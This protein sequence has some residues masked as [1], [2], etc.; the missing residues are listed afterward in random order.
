MKNI[1][2]F[3]FANLPK[4][5]EIRKVSLAQV[6]PIKVGRR[7]QCPQTHKK[8]NRTKKLKLKDLNTYTY[9]IVNMYFKI[10]INKK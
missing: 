7:L 4:I 3:P 2:G 1:L 9:F 10:V 6:S 8:L 5:R